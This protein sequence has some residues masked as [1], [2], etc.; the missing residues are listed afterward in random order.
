LYGR[1]P[2]LSVASRYLDVARDMRRFGIRVTPHGFRFMGPPALQAGLYEPEETKLI[3]RYLKE[4]TVFVDVGANMGYFT[5]LGRH[6]GLKVIAVEPLLF[7]LEYLYVNLESN[8]YYDVEVF[9][10]GLSDHCGLAALFGPGT[11][12]SLIRDWGGLSTKKKIVPLSTLDTIIGDRFSGERLL[13]KL[14]VEGSEFEALNGAHKTLDGYP[15]SVWL[16]EIVLSGNYPGE[17]NPRF[18]DTFE[19]FWA[20]GYDAF[21]VGNEDKMVSRDDVA[22]WVRTCGPGGSFLFKKPAQKK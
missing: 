1:Y 10:V 8:R 13:I 3:E 20:Y 22:E 2:L 15:D 5:C 21:A 16:V 9:P 18:L 7:N 12:A 4:S 11:A 6:A 14:D 17:M 19:R